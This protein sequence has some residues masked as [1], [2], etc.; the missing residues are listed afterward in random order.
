MML[1]RCWLLIAIVLMG[2]AT[3]PALPTARLSVA[4]AM[5]APDRSGFL[6]ADGPRAFSF[7]ADHGPHPGYA[8]EWWYV[9]ANLATAEGRR[10]GVQFTLFHIALAP[11]AT[12]RASEWGSH[13][14]MMG[15]F[16]VADVA[17]SRF[18]AFERFSRVGAGLAGATASPS[19]RVW[20]EDWSLAA[21]D[22]RA[23]PMRIDAA[24]DG[25]AVNLQLD[26]GDPPILQGVDGLS[27]K[28]A[29]PGNASYYYSLMR[30]PTTGTIRVDG[31][32]YAVSGD[33][34][35]D[36]EW[37][38]S[39]LGADQVGW[40]WFALQLDDGS[41]LMFYQLRRRD[42]TADPASKGVLVAGDGERTDVRA[43]DVVLE[44]TRTWRSPRTAADYPAG[45]RLAVPAAAVALEI[46][47]LLADQELPTT[48]VYWE[49]AV[50]VQGTIAGRDVRGYGYVELT[51]YADDAAASPG[52]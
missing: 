18:H 12:P 40:D 3:P 51:G 47:P 34:W 8:V 6:R 16:A 36:R 7:P 9:T 30:L 49:G 39:A 50:R 29:E 31:V 35:L 24:Q 52:R 17:A 22:A 11:D 2:C 26:A 27:Q 38:T 43:A 32:S 19:L 1:Y 48:V 5:R 25:V 10:F 13:A 21:L 46:T 15:H 20:L 33:A 37:S 28:S 14:V 41:E 44:T 4:D 45:W 42:G 23:L